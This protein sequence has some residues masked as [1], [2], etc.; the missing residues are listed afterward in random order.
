MYYYFIQELSESS[1]KLRLS[2]LLEEK[3]IQEAQSKTQLTKLIKEKEIALQRV[4]E[5][6]VVFASYRLITSS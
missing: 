5:L 3:S 4:K 2:D 6:E 1:L